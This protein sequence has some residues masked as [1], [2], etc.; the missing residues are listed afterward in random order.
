MLTSWSEQSTPAALS[1]KSVL[2]APPLRPYST[3][4]S[5]VMPRL[6]PSPTTLARNSRP[7]TRRASL[8]LSPTSAWLSLLALT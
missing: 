6:P 8:A 4:P 1:M 2:L 3:R 7:S 5:W